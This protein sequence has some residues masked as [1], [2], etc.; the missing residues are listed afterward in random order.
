M[1]SQAKQLLWVMIFAVA[2]AY[3]ESAVV[4]YLRRIYGIGADILTAPSFDPQIGAIEAGR[5]LATLLMLL[6]VG[7][8]AGK[9]FKSRLGYAIFAFGIWDIFYYIWLRV[10]IGW[11]VTPLDTDL[12]FLLPLPWW[13]PVLA[14]C[15]VA[16]L[17]AVAG[18][19]LALSEAGGYELRPSSAEWGL[20]VSGI[21]IL[22]YSF[23]ADALAALPA[24]IQTLGKV[25]LTVFD[26]PV[27]LFGLILVAIF[28]WR[29]FKPPLDVSAPAGPAGEN[30][31]GEGS[32]QPK[33]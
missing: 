25:R 28:V 15:L 26:W 5:E 14:P 1:K 27:F 32:Q 9:N 2:M 11:P 30:G 16:L 8:L 7:W 12:L 23:M 22:L 18:V 29:A 4:V 10:F 3:V 21:L 24:D 13:G 33:H 20:L 31:A 19:R 17:M 6:S